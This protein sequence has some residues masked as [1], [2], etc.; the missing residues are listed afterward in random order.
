MKYRI[1]TWRDHADIEDCINSTR[2]YGAVDVSLLD[3]TFVVAENNEGQIVGCVWTF[4]YGRNGY[5][6]YLAVRPKYQ[7][8]GIGVRL[9]VRLRTLLRH[10]GVRFIRGCTLIDNIEMIRIWQAF[11]ALIH[12]PYAIAAIDL[13]E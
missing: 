12:S 9:L 1:G 8:L 13:G 11:G 3:G 10:R 4:H 5:I 7:H 6:D 2:Y